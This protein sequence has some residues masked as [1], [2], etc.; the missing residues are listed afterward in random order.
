MR[1]SK[2]KVKGWLLCQIIR[3]ERNYRFDPG[4]GTAQLKDRDLAAY[5]AYGQYDAYKHILE[6]IK[7]GFL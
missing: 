3:L 5:V 6:E 4:N 2:D 1:F 7:G